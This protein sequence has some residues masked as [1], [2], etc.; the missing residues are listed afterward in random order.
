M[1]MPKIPQ[2]AAPV[3]EDDLDG[4][5][6]SGVKTREQLNALEF[7][8]INEAALKYLTQPPSEKKAPFTALW[9]KELHREM[10]GA[11]WEWAGQFRTTELSVGVPVHK[12]SQE[13]KQ[14]EGDYETWL[15]EKMRQSEIAARIH[16]KLV[17]IHPF[18]NGN[19]RWARLAANIFLMQKRK[20]L[21]FW[22]EDEIFIGKTFRREYIKTLHKADQGDIQEL[23]ALQEKLAGKTE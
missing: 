21:I 15:K 17:W 6:P 20:P 3:G 11:V 12:I 8:N 5:I 13:I 2:G 4:L 22:P 23:T 16:H 14:F 7:S 18:R 9:L 19:G 10:F 1:K